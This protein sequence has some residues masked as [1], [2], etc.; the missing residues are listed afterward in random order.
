M[1]EHAFD[2]IVIQMF[3]FPRFLGNYANSGYQAL[4]LLSVGPSNEAA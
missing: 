3:S 2:V 1:R 4:V